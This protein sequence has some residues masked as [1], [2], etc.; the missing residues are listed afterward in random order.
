VPSEIPDDTERSQIFQ[1]E[2]GKSWR[3]WAW[4]RRQFSVTSVSAIVGVFVCCWGVILSLQTRVVV[5][6]TKVIPVI[7]DEALVTTL[8]A[9][10]AEHDRRIT[11]LEADYRTAAHESETPPVAHKRVK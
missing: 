10:V 4:V 7:Q 1:L 11:Q 9:N 2:F 6:E 8:K 5:L 3:M